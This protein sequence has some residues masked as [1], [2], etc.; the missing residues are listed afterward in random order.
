MPKEG[1]VYIDDAQHYALMLKFSED[2]GNTLDDKI[3][4]LTLQKE[5]NNPN[6]E[7]WD[8]TYDGIN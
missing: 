7:W 5:S 4:K 3:S 8:K 2:S 6:R 1:D